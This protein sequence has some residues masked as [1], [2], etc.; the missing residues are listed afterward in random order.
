MYFVDRSQSF[1]I[2]TGH[3]QRI[4]ATRQMDGYSGPINSLAID[5][6][7][8]PHD[9]NF[10]KMTEAMSG[11]F[12]VVTLETPSA[13]EKPDILTGAFMQ[14]INDKLKVLI[15]YMRSTNK[16]HDVE[17]YEQWS[18]VLGEL[19]ANE[20]SNSKAK[21]ED[22]I[23]ICAYFKGLPLHWIGALSP[24]FSNM[25]KAINKS[26]DNPTRRLIRK[27]DKVQKINDF[28]KMI[29][30][31][32]FSEDGGKNSM[33]LWNLKRYTPENRLPYV[34]HNS[35]ISGNRYIVTCMKTQL[36]DVYKQSVQNLLREYFY[37][38]SKI[39]S[40]AKT[41]LRSLDQVYS[42]KIK[43]LEIEGKDS[44]TQV[45]KEEFKHLLSLAKLRVEE[46]EK[47]KKCV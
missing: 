3:H 37:N 40:S 42:K 17:A 13:A 39:C 15:K 18:L 21:K 10:F 29:I 14:R 45:I 8:S 6:R 12:A 41:L 47:R 5:D 38:E 27:I 24:V 36:K 2:R 19:L 32:L 44:L 28:I 25:M 16:N 46:E 43:S 35:H 33:S 23:G 7:E 34:L 4:G 22:A 11:M 9:L 26:E 30:C 1:S 31:H 20:L